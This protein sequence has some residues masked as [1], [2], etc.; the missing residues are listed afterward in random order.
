MVVHMPPQHINYVRRGAGLTE[1]SPL[2]YAVCVTI[3]KKGDNNNKKCDNDNTQD[4]IRGRP[5][6]ASFEFDDDHPLYL[7]HIQRLRFN[8]FPIPIISEKPP[9]GPKH[10]DTNTDSEQHQ[11]FAEWYGCL[12][13]PWKTEKGPELGL[14]TVST[15]NELVDAV[16]K[17]RTEGAAQSDRS[18][19]YYLNSLAFNMRIN[20]LTRKMLN[21]RR[22]EFARRLEPDRRAP[23]KSDN[24]TSSGTKLNAVDD[25]DQWQARQNARNAKTNT[26]RIRKKKTCYI[27]LEEKLKNLYQR[28]KIKSSRRKQQQTNAASDKH[29]KTHD[30]FWAKNQIDERERKYKAKDKA[31]AQTIHE[32]L[33]SIGERAPTSATL[34]DTILSAIVEQTPT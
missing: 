3:D 14:A 33:H 27:K 25:A 13:W 7:T 31:P 29:W 5:P 23:R 2:E 6:R 12:L 16:N 24:R 26:R 30:H 8:K 17:W 10:D 18:R 1:Y 20:N 32:R 4:N 11:R 28:K 34:L 19:Y 22:T 15:W 21:T 9:P